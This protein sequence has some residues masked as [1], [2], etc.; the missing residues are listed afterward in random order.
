[1]SGM[2]TIRHEQRGMVDVLLVPLIM[3]LVLFLAALGF[4]FWAFTQR[5]HYKDNSD[6]AA[7]VAVQKAVQTTEASDASKYAQAAQQPYDVYVGPAAFGGITAS[8]PRT[9]SAYVVEQDSSNTPIDGY[10]QPG[11]VPDINNQDNSFALRVELVQS[12]YDTTLQQFDGALQ[13]NKVTVSPY[14]LPKVPSVVGSLIKGQIT[15]TNQGSMI[16]MP[17][18]NMTLEVWTESASN[19]NDFNSII[20]P[21]LTFT[22]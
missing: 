13:N 6:Q 16:I 20:L 17:L 11:V 14:T 18:R 3:L 7:A 5:T 4:G 8:Y 9:W 21:H 22:P 12:P 10:F 2:T 1:M 19:E 15:P